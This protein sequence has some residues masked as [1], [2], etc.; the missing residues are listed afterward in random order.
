[1]A[2]NSRPPTTTRWSVS[3]RRLDK[4]GGEVDLGVEPAIEADGE[5]H[6]EFDR[7]KIS[8]R[9][10]AGTIL[11]GFAGAMLIG[12]AVYAAL[13][14]RTHVEDAP[15]YV[16]REQPTADPDT[17]VNPQKGD[18]LVRPVDIV[19]ARQTFTTPT[20]VSVGDRE[21]VR[22]RTFTRVATTLALAPSGL[23]SEVP[24]FNPMKL[25]ASTPSRG[26]A[27]PDIDSERADADVSFVTHDLAKLKAIPSEP[28]LSIEEIQAQI[29]ELLRSDLLDPDKKPLPIPPQL[30]LI[31]T[32]RA[33]T[34][35]PEALPYATI[36]D[37]KLPSPFSKISVRMIPENVTVKGKTPSP[38][39]QRDGDEKLVVITKNQNLRVLLRD[40]G[41][42]A[43]HIDK[44]VR[45]LNSA[46]R[47]R[48]VREGQKL[49]LLFSDVDGDN[50]VDI[51]RV[52]VYSD[53]A[54]ETS[55]AIADSGEFLQVEALEGEASQNIARPARAN[56]SMRLYNSFYE[57][58]LKHRIP[59]EVIDDLVSVFANEIDFNR[60]VA[61]GD[62]FEVFYR[63]SEMKDAGPEILYASIIT[64]NESRR[65]YR[66]PPGPDGH[67][68]FYDENG[69]SSQKFL[70][71]KPVAA[72]E[73]RSGF[74]WRRH[75]IL[76][77][78]R[79]HTGVDWAT[80][81][82]TPIVAAGNGTIIKAKRE[83]GYG[84]RI[85]LQHANGYVTTYSHMVGYA[86][87][88]REG[89]KVRQGQVIGY[90]GSTGLSTGAHLHYE[91][92]V[93]GSYVDPL[94]IRLARSRNLTNRQ[95]AA[96]RRERDRI[97]GL[98]AKAPLA[99]V[100]ARDTSN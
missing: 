51:A 52:S 15:I 40:E 12:S 10:L 77:Y 45:S 31:R 44:I 9:W 13:N 11:T 72:G 96:F 36:G 74:G 73:Q 28:A 66:A 55:I 37:S 67:I 93:N 69:R 18:R 85:E 48:P 23:A 16:P 89:V 17:L 5:L 76:R 56:G 100:A 62:S 4:S 32:S 59:R 65:F 54:L 90:V 50:K 63:M 64:R 75:P 22:H 19:A 58:A 35:N 25:L 70:I 7:R 57:T 86:K 38:A 83:S 82:G 78:A 33:A 87:G 91:V 27:P 46:R 98:I 21:I 39:S 71:R 80:K 94:R 3:D 26:E 42:S 34:G 29:R 97:D 81:T 53:E 84:N 41:A 61:G 49:K 99:R 2:E 14:E 88:M 43:N 79:M 92:I 6:T 24:P 8:T 20:I 68:G 95:M 30:M 1:M 60:A 47:G